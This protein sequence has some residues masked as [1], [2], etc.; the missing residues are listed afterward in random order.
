MAV[1]RGWG[2][3]CVPVLQLV[4]LLLWFLFL[5]FLFLFKSGVFLLSNVMGAFF[6]AGDGLQAEQLNNLKL[7]ILHNL[8]QCIVVVRMFQLGGYVALVAFH[9]DNVNICY[10][11]EVSVT[12][13]ILGRIFS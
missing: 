10:I 5:L 12:W 13:R 7:E 8:T 9:V 1:H 6:A 3:H 4:C 11:L 2:Q